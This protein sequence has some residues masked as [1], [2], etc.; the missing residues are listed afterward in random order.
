MP[1]LIFDAALLAS[2]A[3]IHFVDAIGNPVPMQ[4][5]DPDT[6]YNIQMAS[7]AQPTL[8]T[9]SNSGIPSFLSNFVSPKII[10]VLIAP[11][12]AAEILG[13]EKFGDWT[14]TATTFPMIEYTGQVASYGDYNENGASDA[15]ANFPQ[16]QPY[17]YQTFTQWGQ[18]QLANAALAKLDWATQINL[19]SIAVLN[20][21]QNQTYF[22]GV[23]GLQNY[24]L[25]NDPN[26]STPLTPTSAW[27][28]ATADVIYADV[29]RLFKQLQVQLVGVIQ[30]DTPMVMAM[31]PTQSVNLNKTNSFNINVI[32]QIKKN[33]PNLTFKFAPEYSTVG[34]ELVQLIV[35]KIDEQDTGTCAFTEKLRVHPV[36]M[37][38]SSFRQKKS[39]GSYGAVIY[40]PAAISQMLG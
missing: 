4:F 39:Q 17:H 6:S 24:G 9:T 38:S 27:S 28:G 29:V 26:L 20:K 7:D 36:I 22:F 31:S 8:I 35:P 5:L 3:G 16:R 10:Q 25:L 33:Y 32:D 15:N 34:G 21:Y 11:M 1:K 23:A 13:E 2:T 19:S 18:K 14:T 40:R 37:A 30:T 12:R